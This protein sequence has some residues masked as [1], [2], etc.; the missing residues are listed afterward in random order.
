MGNSPCALTL[1]RCS[2]FCAQCIECIYTSHRSPRY[3]CASTLRWSWQH[4]ID[5]VIAYISIFIFEFWWGDYRLVAP[6][7]LPKTRFF[8]DC[9]DRYVSQSIK[10]SL[11]TST[12]STILPTL[13]HFIPK[14]SLFLLFFFLLSLRPPST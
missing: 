1:L 6:F 3:T 9:V 2:W 8:F 4:S 7:V 13:L 11:E 12:G 5:I 14:I 10:S